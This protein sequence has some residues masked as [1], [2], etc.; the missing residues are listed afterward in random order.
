MTAAEFFKKFGGD[1]ILATNGTRLFPSVK[2]AQ[3]A[4]ET[5]YGK[6]TVGGA[7]NMFGIKAT[8][9]TTPYWDGS[10]YNASTKE[11]ANGVTYT[12]TSGFRAYKTLTDSIRDHSHLLTTLSR[13]KPVLAATTPEDQARALQ[14]AG[15]ATDPGYA[16]KLISI[17]N[18]HGLKELDKKKE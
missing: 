12:T 14:S 10:V 18:M 17:I 16:A 7:N 15:Y 4:L 9:S 2:A 1:F 13:Y 5:G 11:V 3:A 6:S 8:G